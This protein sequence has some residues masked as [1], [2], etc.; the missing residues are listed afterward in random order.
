MKLNE[1]LEQFRV[2]KNTIEKP[3]THTSMNGGKWH[4][5]EKFIQSFYKKI[6]KYIINT[7][8]N[9]Q[10]VERMNDLHPLVIDIDIKYDHEFNDR[11]YTKDT[12]FRIVSFL[13]L[14][15]SSLLDISENKEFAE[16]WVMEKESPYPC[17]TNKKYKTKDGI[18]IVFPNI[19]IQKTS[20]RKIMDI[21]KEQ[22]AVKTIFE[23]TCENPPSNEED[24]LLDGCFSGWQPYGCSKDGESYYKVTEVYRSEDNINLEPVPKEIF[25]E[26]Y[27]NPLTIMKKLSMV[28]HTEE[29]IQ[30]SEEL[31][32]ILDNRLKNTT[33]SSSSAMT[34]NIYGGAN[35]YYVDHNDVI[36]PYE[37]VENN[38]KEL[39]KGL[40]SCLSIERYTEYSKWLAVGMCLHNIDPHNFDMWCEFSRQDPSYDE[41]VCE[42]KWQSFRNEHSG[43]KLGKGSLYHWAKCDNNGKYYEVMTEYLKSKIER[44]ISEGPDAH[45]LL[46]LVISKYF[47]NQYVCVDIN[48]DWYWFNGVR[49]KK[50]MKAHKLK[51]CIHDDIYKIYQEYGDKYD[52]MANDLKKHLDDG[53]DGDLDDVEKYRKKSD[54]CSTFR[55]KL[56]QEPY[57]TT[58]I[59]ALKHIFY[60][61][62]IMEEFDTNNNLIGF[63]N[64][65]YDL[66]NHVFREGR[67][68]DNITLSTKII[69][70]ING[71]MKPGE[72]QE[73]YRK[74]SIPDTA[75][76]LESLNTRVSEMKNFGILDSDM[77]AFISQIIPNEEVRDYTMRM[78][79]SCLSGENREESF[80]IWTGSGGNGKSKLVELIG[81]ALG[82][83]AC[84]LPV[85]LL[86]QKRKASGA[87]SPEM[88]RT[89]GKRFVV[90]QEP[91]VNETLNVGEMKEITGNDKIQ[92]RGLYKEPFE[93]TPQFKL[94]LMCNQLPVVPSDDDGTWRRLR[95]TP[96]VSRFVKGEDV[97]IKLNRYPIDK[98]LKQKLPYWIVPFMLTLLG[99]W[100]EYDKNGII[101]PAAVT[102]KTSEY[103]NANDLIGQWINDCC[104]QVE[105]TKDG[106]NEY[107][108]GEFDNLYAEFKEWCSS[109]EEKNPPE[110]KAV[111]EALKKWQASS[112]FGLSIGK[113]K[114][115]SGVNGFEMKPRFNLKVV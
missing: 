72:N 46:A 96:F 77:R 58:I 104:A 107:A 76:P 66:K 20:Y 71:S 108:P 114:V 57:V 90:M 11:Q 105:N 84:N 92:A 86:T 64:G 27:T 19:I 8:D 110:K 55:K 5:P 112:K 52:K 42:T 24:T 87:A 50:T 33:S 97:D 7:G 1:F 48:E 63:E 25:Q 73:S 38:E 10:L 18:H 49:W 67:P 89:R 102:D 103:R 39:I 80:N 45:H 4:I 78:I 98:T 88:A 54:K 26:L 100:E 94:F 44:S 28:G 95:A 82:E 91:D 41:N 75:I 3:I 59:G 35:A 14:N 2:S 74:R 37:I 31:K 43:A 23:D 99:E 17:K 115:D 79:S 111:K 40:V 69:L 30:Y 56:Y 113:K 70:P 32:C 47:E 81:L 9:L 65:I 109:Q 83:Y 85:A 22:N 61:E 101:V 93:F 106:V 53:G 12:V 6:V 68:E 13:W 51:Q 15:L 60:K 21:L 34:N 62:G 36:N 16:I 29:N